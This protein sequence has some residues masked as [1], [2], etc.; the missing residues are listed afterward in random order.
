MIR[1]RL[2]VSTLG[3]KKIGQAER[4]ENICRNPDRREIADKTWW[5]ALGSP[6]F[7]LVFALFLL[8]FCSCSSV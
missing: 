3:N 7:R 2:R 5:L 4:D 8:C 1:R 6:C